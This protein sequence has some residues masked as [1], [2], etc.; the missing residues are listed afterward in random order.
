MSRFYWFYWQIFSSAQ[1]CLFV[2]VS[3]GKLLSL[4]WIIDEITVWDEAWGQVR[5][6]KCFK[7]KKKD[8]CSARCANSSLSL[9]NKCNALYHRFSLKQPI[10]SWYYE[11]NSASWGNMQ[12]QAKQ[13]MMQII[14]NMFEF[15]FVKIVWPSSPSLVRPIK[16]CL[17]ISE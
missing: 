15:S 8:S 5:T 1:P 11:K 7:F 4:F 16:V 14:F 12:E 9:K 10:Q 6:E 3:V 13:K 17:I 2:C